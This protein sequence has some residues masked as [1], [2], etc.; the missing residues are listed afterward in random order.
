MS[1]EKVDGIQPMYVQAQAQ[2]VSQ[3]GQQ[4]EQPESLIPYPDETIGTLQNVHVS[5]VVLVKANAGWLGV[6]LVFHWDTF[7]RNLKLWDNH[8][9]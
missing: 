2:V 8:A 1:N 5:G 4:Q 6:V 7:L 3:P 9:V